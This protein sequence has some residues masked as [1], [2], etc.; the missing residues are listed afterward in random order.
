ME[1]FLDLGY[2]DGNERGLFMYHKS[3]NILFQRKLDPQGDYGI[4][5][6]FISRMYGDVLFGF[7]IMDD[8]RIESIRL[9]NVFGITD[10]VFDISKTMQC[11]KILFSPPISLRLY[12]VEII[13]N[14]NF[15]IFGIY[16]MLFHRDE[17]DN[18][19]ETLKLTEGEPTINKSDLSMMLKNV[20]LQLP[21]MISEKLI[22]NVNDKYVKR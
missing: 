5:T 20:F 18:N 16:G 15:P 8:A 12:S 1:D 17:Y 11:G 13:A 14:S 2:T 9:K 19:I 21:E 3:Q 6:T 7:R 22:S 4:L 10:K